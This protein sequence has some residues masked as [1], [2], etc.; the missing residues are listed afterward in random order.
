MVIGMNKTM[1]I[2]VKGAMVQC[3]IISRIE[4]IA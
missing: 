2:V 3:F 1:N 4:R